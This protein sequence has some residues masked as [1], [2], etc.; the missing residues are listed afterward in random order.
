[1][2]DEFLEI[3]FSIHLT[4]GKLEPKTQ[5]GIALALASSIVVWVL[6]GWNELH[7]ITSDRSEYVGT[8]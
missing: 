2:E 4:A 1:V 3:R 6:Y 5:V 7:C 8:L